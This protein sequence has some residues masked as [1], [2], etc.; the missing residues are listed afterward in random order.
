MHN[1][2]R[3][4]LLIVGGG[5]QGGLIALSALSHIPG[6]RVALIERNERPGGDHSWCL[7]AADVAEPARA[8]LDP[9]IVQRWPGYDVRFPTFQRTIDGPHAAISSQRL[10]ERL[11]ETIARA[12]GC[13]LLLGRA[14][15]HIG[16]HSV[17]LEDGRSV[18][19]T[20]VVDARGPSLDAMTP[21]ACGFQKYLGLELDFEGEHGL[22]RPLFMDGSI[23]QAGGLRF[24]HVLPADPTRLL[25]QEICFSRSPALERDALRLS[26]LEHAARFGRVTAIVREHSG[27][28]PMPWKSA[29]PEPRRSPLVAGFRGGFF[30]PVTGALLPS[31]VRLAQ[32]IGTRPAHAVF[33]RDFERLCRAHGAQFRFALR[34]N[35]LLFEGF[36]PHDMW[37]MAE[38][39]F[40]LPDGVVHRFFGMQMAP[41]DRAR[42]FA[43][44]PPKGLR[45]GAALAAVRP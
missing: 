7:H 10:C 1:T 45:L 36:A 28:L 3:F 37:R 23:P 2:N 31:A 15:R 24:L 33:D 8:W 44:R 20:L 13:Q 42:L 43:G 26:V 34:M 38:R 27:A 18:D 19:A 6:M 41:A 5:L 35:R 16:P 11:V 9:L 12:P 32:H 30:H 4:D 39:F 29:A 22:S 21:V 17:I 40:R 25:V 14:A